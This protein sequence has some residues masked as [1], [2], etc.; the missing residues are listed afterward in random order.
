LLDLAEPT[1]EARQQSARNAIGQEE[2]D[3]LLKEQVGERRSDC[4]QTVSPS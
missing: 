4:H 1:H 2:V 3:V